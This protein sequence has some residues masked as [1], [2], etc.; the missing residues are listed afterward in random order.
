M[1]ISF[2]GSTLTFSDSTTMTTAAVAGPTGPTGPSGPA[3]PTGS[4]G[5]TGPTGSF[6][7]NNAGGVG[8]VTL[9]RYNFAATR[10]STYAGACIFP[11]FAKNTC[12]CGGT[13]SSESGTWRYY[14]PTSSGSINAGLFV[15][16]S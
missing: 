13:P 12:W 3:G 6:C 2:S 5:S 8:S 10:G 11:R 14:G 7:T 4:P 15:R 16:V 9:A 1:S